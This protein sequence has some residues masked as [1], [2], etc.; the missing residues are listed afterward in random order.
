[1]YFDH[2]GENGSIGQV[3]LQQAE[4]V[5][6]I[7]PTSTTADDGEKGLGEEGGLALGLG[8]GSVEGW[9]PLSVTDVEGGETLL[10]REIRR[11]THVGRAI[12]AVVTET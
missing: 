6:F 4:T 7:S 1:M 2:S 8:L 10:L 9:Q 11:G 5:R 12:D 3:F